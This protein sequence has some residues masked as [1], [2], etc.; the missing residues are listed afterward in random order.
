MLRNIPNILTISRIIVIPII[1][2]SFYFDDRVLAHR[3]GA[4]LFLYASV[5]DFLDGYLARKWNLSSNFGT[6]L[7]PIAD[8]LL[9]IITLFMLAVFWKIQILPCLLII[10]REII[11]SGFREFFAEV[12]VKIH[13]SYLAKIKTAIQMVAIFTLTLGSKGSGIE[14]CDLLG[15]ILLWVAAILTIVTGFSY[16]KSCIGYFRKDI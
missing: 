3:V 11:V 16:F 6:M 5:T 2:C 10:A 7:D 9:V 14:L 13:V 15:Q 1:V 4:C 8:K 12:Q